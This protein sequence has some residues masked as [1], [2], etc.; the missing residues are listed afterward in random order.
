V[1]ATGP[2][3][4]DLPE[5]QDYS[6]PHPG[7]QLFQRGEQDQPLVQART[8][9]RRLDEPVRWGFTPSPIPLV[10]ERCHQGTPGVGVQVVGP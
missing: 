4:R 8:R 5:P 9:R 7:W 10:Q 2:N 6:C 3:H 1:T